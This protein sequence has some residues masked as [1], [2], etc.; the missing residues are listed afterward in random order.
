MYMYV[1][2]VYTYFRFFDVSDSMLPEIRSSS[3]V[4]GN[5]SAGPL[6]GCPLSG[7][8]ICCNKK[9]ESQAMSMESINIE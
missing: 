8:N 7:V 9:T 5:I 2:N 1:F 4:Y 3:E 6:K